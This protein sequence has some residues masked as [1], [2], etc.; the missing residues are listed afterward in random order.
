[1]EHYQTAMQEDDQYEAL[2]QQV[3]PLT[4]FKYVLF[5]SKLVHFGFSPLFFSLC[6]V[7]FCSIAAHVIMYL[8]IVALQATWHAAQAHCQLN[9]M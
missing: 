5:V 3:Q 7:F 8:S 4:L 9:L 6:F 2:A 1:M